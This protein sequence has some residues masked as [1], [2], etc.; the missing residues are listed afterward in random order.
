MK[1]YRFGVY[2]LFVFALGMFSQFLFSFWGR[3]AVAT[4]QPN[5]DHATTTAKMVWDY[6][7]AAEGCHALY[8]LTSTKKF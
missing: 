1:Y 6:D 7:T 3:P 8:E 4:P 2:S 5:Y